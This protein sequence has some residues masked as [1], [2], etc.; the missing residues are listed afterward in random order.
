ME[1]E[2]GEDHREHWRGEGYGGEVTD[3]KSPDG[4]KHGEQYSAANHGLADDLDLGPPIIEAKQG[5]FLPVDKDEK[6]EN[7]KQTPA[8]TKASFKEGSFNFLSHRRNSNCQVLQ[9]SQV[10]LIYLMIPLLS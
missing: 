4:F 10:V 3:G 6:S 2:G 8:I 1:D 7:L 5:V 9:F